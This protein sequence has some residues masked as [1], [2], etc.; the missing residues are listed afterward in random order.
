MWFTICPSSHFTN[1]TKNQ[2][3]FVLTFKRGA[4]SLHAQKLERSHSALLRVCLRRLHSN[5]FNSTPPTPSWSNSIIE[6]QSFFMCL[7]YGL[8]PAVELWDF[9]GNG[10]KCHFKW[11]INIFVNINKINHLCL[12]TFE[13][14]CQVKIFCVPLEQHQKWNCKILVR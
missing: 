11:C 4:E 14:S 3:G 6:F 9:G 2:S 10:L 1:Q 5:F 13:D 12:I 8:A 7:S